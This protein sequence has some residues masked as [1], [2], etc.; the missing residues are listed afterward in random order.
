MEY[1]QLTWPN[2]TKSKVNLTH[3]EKPGKK[4]LLGQTSHYIYKSQWSEIEPDRT[5][6]NRH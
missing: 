1:F 3:P 5:N 4:N 6:S 2:P